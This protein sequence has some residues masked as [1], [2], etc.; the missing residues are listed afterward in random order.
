MSK[1][2]LV[3]CDVRRTPYMGDHQLIKDMRLVIADDIFQA[4][5]KYEKWWSDRTDEYSVYYSA[6]GAEITETV[7]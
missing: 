3:R 6:L 7:E 2:F 4:R 5:E 1:I